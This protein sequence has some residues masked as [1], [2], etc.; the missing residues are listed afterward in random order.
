MSKDNRTWCEGTGKEQHAT[1]QIAA[2][3]AKNQ[4]RFGKPTQSYRCDACGYFHT[5]SGKPQKLI[6]TRQT[7]GPLV[8][9][10]QR[11]TRIHHGDPLIYRCCRG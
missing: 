7:N 3:V 4:A 1:P 8:I 2:R 9:S 10:R 11:E 5:G 6:R